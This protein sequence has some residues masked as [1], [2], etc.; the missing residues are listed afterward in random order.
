MPMKK[1]KKEFMKLSRIIQFEALRVLYVN[2]FESKILSNHS[3]RKI[4]FSNK[5]R[6]ILI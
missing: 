3:S 1:E 6:L 4:Y 5:Y 2:I